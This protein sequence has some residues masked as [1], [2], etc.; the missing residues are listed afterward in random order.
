VKIHD[1]ENMTADEL[2]ARSAELAEALNAEPPA[3]L[4]ARYVQART[5]AKRRDEKLAEQGKTITALRT[6]LDATTQKADEAMAAAQRLAE[7]CDALAQAAEAAQVQRADETAA[8]GAKLAA[9]T[10]RA[11]R[12]KTE[13]IRNNRA[14]TTAAKVLNDAQAEQSID[15]ADAGS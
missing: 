12:L 3:D 4:A 1:I 2:K 8:L 5:D 15:N 9:E 7:R 6:G 13:A 11:N 10:A 14:L